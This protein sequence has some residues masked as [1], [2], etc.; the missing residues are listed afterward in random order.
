M[1]IFYSEVDKNLQTELRAR[2]ESFRK[3][4]TDSLNYMLT[5]IANVEI[6]AYE[7]TSSKSLRVATLGGNTVR[8]GRFMPTGPDGYLMSGKKYQ[9]SELEFN[10]TTGEVDLI[11][12]EKEDR[13]TRIGPYITALDVSI[14]DHSMGLLNKASFNATIPNPDRDLDAFEEAWMRPG[15]Y[16]RIEIVH[17]ST[18]IASGAATD[19]LLTKLVIPNRAKLK[20]LYPD[21]DILE[22]EQEI[23]EMRRFVFEGLITAFDFSYSKD[24]M[25]EVNINLTGTSNVYTNLSMYI[26]PADPESTNATATAATVPATSSRE[27]YGRLYDRFESLIGQFKK[28]DPAAAKLTKFLIPYIDNSSAKSV[29]TSVYTTDQFILK[30]EQFPALV[31]TQVAVNGVS[32]VPGPPA[33]STNDTRYITLGALVQHVNN[34]VLSKLSGAQIICTDIEC[35]SVYYSLMASS[36]P[37]EILFLPKDPNILANPFV[38]QQPQDHNVYG[39]LVYYQ[40]VLKQLTDNS[41]N[42]NVL[43]QKGLWKDWPGVYEKSPDDTGKLYPSRIF[44]NLETIE[45]I[46]NNLSQKNSTAFSVNTFIDALCSKISDA[47]GNAINLTLVTYPYDTSKLYLTDS[48]FVRTPADTSKVIAFSVPMFA[49]HPNGTIVEDFQFSAKL[50]DSVK[51]LSYVL[52]SNANVSEEDI[53]P[54]MNFMYNGKNKD[55]VNRILAQYN[56]QHVQAANELNDAKIKFGQSPDVPTIQAELNRALKKYIQYPTDDIKNANLLTAPIF[57]FTVDFTIGGINGFRYGDVLTFD[58]LPRK[59]RV[60]TVFSVISINHTVSNQGEWKT[61]ITCIQRP[62]IE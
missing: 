61:K 59:Y 51:N 39:N 34:Y 13:S 38:A 19:G 55:A 58:G 10:E 30:G 36:N 12:K 46:V 18:A 23:R 27:F 33:S 60:N 6:T 48:K 32:N 54:Y 42:T 45:A 3:R 52:N 26:N 47:S 21:W 57:P 2:G 35:F 11:T 20:N 22:L 29:V 16:A 24:G 44:I 8:T 37:D 9:Q 15:R 4:D 40:D 43:K 14:G 49:N 1:N 5:K 56:R 25:V 7:T 50:P 41:V 28:A 17:P 53:A 62:S 31:T